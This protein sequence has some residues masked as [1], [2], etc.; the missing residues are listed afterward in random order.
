MMVRLAG[1]LEASTR[2][3]LEPLDWAKAGAAA[4][5]AAATIRAR[6]GESPFGR[7][8]GG[9]TERRLLIA[10][11][12]ASEACR[13]PFASG[14]PPARPCPRPATR[15]GNSPASCPPGRRAPAR[16]QACPRSH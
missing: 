8:F 4:N 15:R 1:A 2:V 10:D 14:R 6:M 12:V 13:P 5:R 9:L 16:P 7:P 3:A 11:H